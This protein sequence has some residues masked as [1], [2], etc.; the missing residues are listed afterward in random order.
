[1]NL[2]KRTFIAGL[3]AFGLS[4]CSGAAQSTRPTARGAVPVDLRPVQTPAFMEWVAR[5][6]PR[7]TSAGISSG[8]FDAAF[9]NAGYIQRVVDRDRNQI[10]TRR[11]LEDYLSIAVSDERMT[12]GR[13]AIRQ[14]A[15][16]LAAV[17]QRYGVD[18]NIVAAIW[19][20]ESLFGERRGD[21]PVV[22]AT[23]TLA[24]DGRR[25]AFY[26]SQLIA[27]LKILERGDTTPD[28]MIGSWAGAMGHTQF[29][30]TSY[31]S[32]AVDFTGDG[33]RDIWSDDPTDSLASTAAYLS[34]NG[35]QSGLKWGS[36]EGTGGPSGRTVQPQSGGIKFIVTRN[37]DALKS[38]NNSDFYAIGI[39]HL[40]DRLGG[41]GPLRGSFPPDENGLSKADRQ[42]VQ[43]GLA[44][45]GFD[46]GAADGV[47]GGQTIA[48][49][50]AFQEQQGM[51]VTGIASRDVLNALR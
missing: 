10:Q 34:R 9:A 12:K 50:T 38:Y 13:A 43:R 23:A 37:F 31:Q 16:T 6:K 5:F 11:T 33:R 1:M 49:I 8:T 2:N 15:N 36:E 14:H 27:A 25:G 19:G 7:A 46:V 40:A 21:I 20:M 26:E 17:E 18:R 4:A 32:F 41:A 3:G 29:I 24:F 42:T 45:R 22:S 44:R 35:W 48:A 30:P 51:A 39:G 28:Q 47:I